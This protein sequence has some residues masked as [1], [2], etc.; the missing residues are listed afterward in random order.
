MIF[1]RKDR[2]TAARSSVQDSRAQE[3]GVSKPEEFSTKPRSYYDAQTLHL[4]RNRLYQP[5]HHPQPRKISPP[6][7][8]AGH[9]TSSEGF[10]AAYYSIGISN[11]TMLVHVSGA[12]FPW[13]D[14][15]QLPGGGLDEER[16]TAERGLWLDIFANNLEA[17]GKCTTLPS[18]IAF[19]S[20]LCRIMM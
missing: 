3:A 19:L 2:A 9:N 14:L 18:A 6:F 17:I 13:G 11:L 20:K 4:R 8:V 16:E 10:I 12:A 5:L 1:P 7:V 15:S